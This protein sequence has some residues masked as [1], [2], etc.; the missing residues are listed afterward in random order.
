MGKNQPTGKFQTN[1]ESWEP[2]LKD[3]EKKSYQEQQLRPKTSSEKVCD[4]YPS[5]LYIHKLLNWFRAYT[6][7]N[8]KSIRK[9]SLVNHLSSIDF[10]ILDKK[11]FILHQL[12]THICN[13]CYQFKTD[14][15]WFMIYVQN[16][17]AERKLY[18]I[19]QVSI[20]NETLV[21]SG[22]NKWSVMV[23]VFQ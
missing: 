3:K 7:K 5:I 22:S 13:I 8:H 6:T 20:W 2:G 12:M 17:Y 19:L 18:I 14:D 23:N 15:K 9:L 16:L 1:L 4:F 11:S 10:F 21:Y